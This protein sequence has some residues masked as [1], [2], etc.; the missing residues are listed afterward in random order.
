MAREHEGAD[1]LGPSLKQQFGGVY[2]SNEGFTR[3]SAEAAI[4]RGDV[5]AVSFGK[6]WIANPDLVARFRE[7]AA[8]NTPVPETFYAHGP[9]G[10]VDY[11]TLS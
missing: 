10:Y 8:L 4:E 6:A 5:D 2:I 7:G 3:E 9:E 11:P 1:W